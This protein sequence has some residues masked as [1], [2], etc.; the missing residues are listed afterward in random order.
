MNNTNTTNTTTGGR[1]TRTTDIELAAY[2]RAKGHK[3][4]SSDQVNGR[5]IE[6]VFPPEA[7][8]DIDEFLQGDEVS[9]LDLFAALRTL[10]DLIAQTQNNRTYRRDY[11]PRTGTR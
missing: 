5:L 11:E 4:E 9:A 10:R 3:L 2:L 6:F 8:H 7:A 1:P